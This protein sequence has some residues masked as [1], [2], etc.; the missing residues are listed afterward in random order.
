MAGSL[1]ATR[2]TPPPNSSSGVSLRRAQNDAQLSEKLHSH[3][4][5]SGENISAED[6]VSL[7]FF[8]SLFFFGEVNLNSVRFSGVVSKVNYKVAH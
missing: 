7:I 6:L 5:Q 3:L 8:F 2:P 1:P 4:R